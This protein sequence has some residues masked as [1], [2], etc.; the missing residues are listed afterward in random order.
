VPTPI[1]PDGKL[2]AYITGDDGVV[3]V[4][5]TATGRERFSLQSPGNT[6]I[7][8]FR[9]A[10]RG[11]ALISGDDWGGIHVWDM[12]NGKLIH[13]QHLHRSAIN[14][15]TISFTRASFALSSD[16]QYYATLSNDSVQAW[17]SSTHQPVGALLVQAA[18]PTAADFNPTGTRL[19]TGG[20][21]AQVWDVQTGHPLTPP[22]SLGTG[23]AR[24]IDYSPD[25]KFIL[26]IVANMARVWAAPPE[27]ARGGT[28]K[29]IL[30]LATICSGQH[31]TDD[32]AFISAESEFANID[33]LR[34][35]IDTLPASDSFAQWGRWFLSTSASRSIA[36][37]FTITP[38]QAKNLMGN[39]PGAD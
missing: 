27:A 9:F 37:G 10:D 13:S 5:E 4:C 11:Q 15:T 32:G 25:G 21:T 26:T 2:V 34:R 22:M 7:T 3:H 17:D 33:T 24:S 36:P 14:R 20:S 31:L 30:A 35:E 39:R 6:S 16:G 29:W 28:P 8:A 38:V 19:V 12:S 18:P 1:S 23:R